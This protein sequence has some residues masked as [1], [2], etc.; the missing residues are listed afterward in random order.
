MSS[1]NFFTI[2]P[3]KDWSCL[4]VLTNISIY[5]GM[6]SIYICKYTLILKEVSKYLNNMSNPWHILEEKNIKRRLKISQEIYLAQNSSCD[7]MK[8]NFTFTYSDIFLFIQ[9]EKSFISFI[10][11]YYTYFSL[12]LYSKR[13][14]LKV[15]HFFSLFSM[16][17]LYYLVD[18]YGEL[19]LYSRPIWWITS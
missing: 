4:I 10:I 13:I 3:K 18:Q 14:F 17:N 7:T 15:F 12:F 19:I 9:E 16:L 5:I 1:I 11:F 6:N 8:T 2:E